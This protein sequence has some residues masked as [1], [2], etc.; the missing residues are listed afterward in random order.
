M[1][2]PEPCQLLAQLRWRR[3]GPHQMSFGRFVY[4]L[5]A[6]LIQRGA[7]LLFIGLGSERSD[8][9]LLG[10]VRR[11]ASLSGLPRHLQRGDG[12]QQARRVVGRRMEL[13]VEELLAPDRPIARKGGGVDAE[14]HTAEPAQL[15]P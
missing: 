12:G 13:L 9:L 1:V 15:T 7:R 4:D 10:A 14:C 8:S 6:G 5:A 2:H 3:E 11:D